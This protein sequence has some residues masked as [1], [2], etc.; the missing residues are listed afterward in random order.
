ML[1]TTDAF[2]PQTTPKAWTDGEIADLRRLR[3]IEGLGWDE[4]AVRLDRTRSGV[5]SKFKYL[6]YEFDRSQKIVV[7]STAE[8]VPADVLAER[9][10]R[11]AVMHQRS[12]VGQ[13]CGDPPPGM[14]A[15]DKKLGRGF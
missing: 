3:L 8:Q 4:I 12:M 7:Q 6:Q 2:E 11:L 10:R 15:L 13:L 1:M 14:S 9:A 5:K